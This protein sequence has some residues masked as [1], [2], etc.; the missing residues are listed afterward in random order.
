MDR[1]PKHIE[2]ALV[3][4]MNYLTDSEGGIEQDVD[5]EFV[6]YKNANGDEFV[7]NCGMDSAKAAVK[8]FCKQVICEFRL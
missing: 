2:R 8:D 6:K 4:V 1:M 5:N 7:A 3:N